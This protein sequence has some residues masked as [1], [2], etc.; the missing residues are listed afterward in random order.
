VYNASRV[1]VRKSL[2]GIGSADTLSKIYDVLVSTFEK[3]ND[4]ICWECSK[5]RIKFIYKLLLG[6]LCTD[7]D[8]VC[9]EITRVPADLGRG[10]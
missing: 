3:E 8:G 6:C 7:S 10:V 5:R 4:W 1:E 9:E 2:D